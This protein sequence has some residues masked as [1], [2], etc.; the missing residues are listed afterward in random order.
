[1]T[2]RPILILGSLGLAATLFAYGL[3]NRLANEQAERI[4]PAQAHVKVESPGLATFDPDICGNGNG[5]P[6]FVCPHCTPG[7]TDCWAC[8]FRIPENHTIVSLKCSSGLIKIVQPGDKAALTLASDQQSDSPMETIIARDLMVFAV[9]DGNAAQSS[10]QNF[11]NGVIK[12]VVPR[13]LASFIDENREKIS[14]ILSGAN[15]SCPNCSP[16]RIDCGACCGDDPVDKE[17]DW[18]EPTLEQDEYRGN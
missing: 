4:N 7:K 15:G 6:Q 1:M 12:I 11:T 10:D 18:S 5:L 16:G 9:T 13:K 17:I 14:V 2:I 8:L 3:R